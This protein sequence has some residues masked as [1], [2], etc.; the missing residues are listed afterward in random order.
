MQISDTMQSVCKTC[1]QLD[2]ELMQFV[3][4]VANMPEQKVSLGGFCSAK[5][6]KSIQLHLLPCTTLYLCAIVCSFSCSFCFQSF[7]VMSA[8][9]VLCFVFRW[10]RGFPSRAL[11][12]LCI[13]CVLEKVF[14]C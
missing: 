2:R 6:S 8:F 13:F 7:V 5:V 12:I 10:I 9:G 4:S 11:C 14:Y 1:V 3:Q